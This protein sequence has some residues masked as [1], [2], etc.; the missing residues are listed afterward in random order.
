MGKKQLWKQNGSNI[1]DPNHHSV[2]SIKENQN[3]NIPF[4][5]LDKSTNSL[6]FK[7]LVHANSL[8]TTLK[9]RMA[10]GLSMFRESSG[11]VGCFKEGSITVKVA[12]GDIVQR[13]EY[14]G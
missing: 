6:G 3:P 2:V 8:P 10:I 4:G 12:I 1:L 11:V 14:N 7:N 13:L 5:G 9:D